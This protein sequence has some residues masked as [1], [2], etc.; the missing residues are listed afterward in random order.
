MK[1]LTTL[2]LGL[3]AGIFT[4]SAQAQT[5]TDAGAKLYARPEL[6]VAFPGHFDTAVGGG[7]ALGYS[8]VRAQAVEVEAIAFSSKDSGYKVKFLPVVGSYIYSL[9]LNSDLQVK[10]GGSIGATWEKADYYWY[11]QSTS[12]F[13]IGARAGLSYGLAKNVSLDLDASLLHLNE[14]SIVTSGN[15]VLTTIGVNFRF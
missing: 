3:C 10:F 8:I 13:T 12:T 6:V 9:K 14:T 4:M 2:I 7:L 1:K 15:I 11:D 5:S